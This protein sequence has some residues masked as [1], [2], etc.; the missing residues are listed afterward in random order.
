MYFDIMQNIRDAY[1]AY[2]D[3]SAHVLVRDDANP[4]WRAGA[5]TIVSAYRWYNPEEYEKWV[6]GTKEAIISKEVERRMKIAN[7]ENGQPAAEIEKAVQKRLI[8][9]TAI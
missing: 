6:T 1:A 3:D 8:E 7:G 9:K 5:W 2:C 4:I